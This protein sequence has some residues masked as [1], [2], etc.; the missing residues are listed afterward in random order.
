MAH[1][2][3]AARKLLPG[4][5]IF[6]LILSSVNAQTCLIL[7]SAKA[8]PDGTVSLDL[9]L[10][11]L[12]GPPPAA[13]Q[14]TF[15]YSSSAILSITVDDGPALLS[16]GKTTFCAEGAAAYKCL[17]TGVN[18]N[19]VPNGVIA[20]VTAVLAPGAHTATIQVREALGA[21]IGGDSIAI[22]SESGTITEGGGSSDRELIR[23]SRP[24]VG[25]GLCSAPEQEKDR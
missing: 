1:F 18:S 12:S 4:L 23:R 20:K 22:S 5:P 16:T 11:S 7:S 9:S 3:F 14:W 17:I 24:P 2:R 6:A 13:V 15:R 25:R 10:N 8:R 19:T 21:S